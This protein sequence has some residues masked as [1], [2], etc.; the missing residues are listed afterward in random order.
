MAKK[1]IQDIYIVKRSIMDIK[2]SDVRDG[3]FPSSK[4]SS[5]KSK[6]SETLPKEN[7]VKEE[8][9]I[10]E[11]KT[12]YIIEEKK[13]LS[14]NSIITLWII[15][16]V[17]FATLLFFLSSL[18]AVATLTITPKNQNI[19]LNDTYNITSDKNVSSSTLHFQVV[20]ITKKLLKNLETDGEQYIERKATGKAMLY[21]NF[22]SSAQRLIN[23]T[24]LQTKDG[25]IYK[26]RES[27]VIPGIKTVN[28][29]KT[30]GSVEVEIIADIPGDKYNMKLSDFKGDFTIPGFAG[31]TKFTAFYGRLSSDMVGGYIGNI[32][33]VSDEK[34]LAGRNELKTNLKEELIKEV[35]AKNIDQYILFNNNYYTQCNDLMDDTTEGK[36]TINEEC[37]I[38]AIVFDKNELSSFIAKNKVPNFDKSK[39]DIMWND[40]DSVSISGTTAKL[41]NETN[42]KA[43]FTGPAQVVWDIDEQKI[44]DSIVGQD[45]SII[46][47]VIKN[48]SNYL[49]EIKAVIRPMWKKTFPTNSRKIKIIDTIRDAIK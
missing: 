19:S 44:L 32:K 35:Y 18:F 13:H 16:I 37:T 24:R 34:L 40:N 33:K 45:K 49:T 31:S 17:S 47:S 6:L 26:I 28:G 15:C 3:F 23:N 46:G 9:D 8:I 1:L 21:N 25:L 48:N 7:P 11:N 2:K 14:K 20:T 43:V 39:V 41:W 22:S 10:Y 27:V 5:K 42:L 12:E 36:Y 29:V 30:P 38:N 4:K